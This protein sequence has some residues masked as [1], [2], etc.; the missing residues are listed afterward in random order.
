MI[1]A[2]VM[3]SADV[4][5]KIAKVAMPRESRKWL[6]ETTPTE[7]R[8]GRDTSATMQPQARKI[9]H[10]AILK[11]QAFGNAWAGS[12]LHDC[13]SRGNRLLAHR[14]RAALSHAAQEHDHKSNQ[15]VL[16]TRSLFLDKCT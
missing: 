2:M 1:E 8:I 11:H 16:H 3:D 6:L 10:A 7:T 5:K 13:A 15:V 9:P 4:L 12:E 14:A